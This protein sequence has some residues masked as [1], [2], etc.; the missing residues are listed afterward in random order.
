VLYK[1]KTSYQTMLT[2]GSTTRK[3]SVRD[4]LLIFNVTLQCRR[5]PVTVRPAILRSPRIFRR[6]I[7]PHPLNRQAAAKKNCTTTIRPFTPL[8]PF[9]TLLNLSPMVRNCCRNGINDGERVLAFPIV[10]LIYILVPVSS[11]RQRIVPLPVENYRRC[12]EREWMHYCCWIMPR[13]LIY[14]LSKLMSTDTS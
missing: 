8:A 11:R 13:S 14:V 1:K 3:L 5:S 10:L 6:L 9:T 4:T 12:F 7:L 2:H